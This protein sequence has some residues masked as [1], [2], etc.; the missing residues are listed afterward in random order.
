[1]LPHKVKQHVERSKEQREFY[2]RITENQCQLQDTEM[3]LGE[4][5]K[6]LLEHVLTRAANAR[7]QKGILRRDRAL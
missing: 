3:K 6:A 1:M 5:E 4:W 7:T 2:K